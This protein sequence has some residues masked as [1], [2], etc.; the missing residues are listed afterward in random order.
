MGRL[1]QAK[2]DVA[3]VKRDV[4][5]LARRK[6]TPA[7][8]KAHKAKQKELAAAQRRLRDAMRATPILVIRPDGTELTIDEMKAQA[9][10]RDAAANAADAAANA[11][12]AAAAFEVVVECVS[13]AD[14]GDTAFPT[15]CPA[16]EAADLVAI[17]TVRH[18]ALATVGGPDR[19]PRS[20][21]YT[22]VLNLGA[23]GGYVDGTNGRCLIP[24]AP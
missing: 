15:F 3:D 17:L 19:Y 12:A 24:S 8:K 5:D 9:A 2:K 14:F 20:A 18:Y 4:A 21:S 16:S 23:C 22:R 13:A 6:A 11:A 10:A 1:E 7:N